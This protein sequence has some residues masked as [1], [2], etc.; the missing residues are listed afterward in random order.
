M[1]D[2]TYTT[3]D[4]QI[5][6]LKSQHLQF[7]DEENAKSRLQKYGYYNIINGYRD[8]FIIRQDST[9][10]Y[11]PGTTFEQIFALFALDHKLRNAVLLSTIDFEEQLKASV[12]E[13]I[14]CD[15]GTTVDEYLNKDNYRDKRVRDPRFSR[16][17][18]LLS[19][20]SLAHKA[21][22]EPIKYYKEQHGLIPP[23]ILMKGVFFGT[24]VN[25]IRLFKSPQRDKL[26]VSLYGKDR[27]NIPDEELKG[28][29]S[30]SLFLFLEYRNHA[31]H[32][33][34]IYNYIPKAK[35][36]YMDKLS[37]PQGLPQL[38]YAFSYLLHT[39]PYRLMKSVL[40]DALD[41]YGTAYPFDIDR[42]GRLTGFTIDKT[43]MVFL[44]ERT[45]K[46]HLQSSCSGLTNLYST[47][48]THAGLLGYTPCKRC[49]KEKMILSIMN[50]INNH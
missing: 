10:Y 19:M 13:I 46:Y 45:K 41:E 29:M 14:A 48:L 15:F 2:L 43:P 35:V 6:K 49:C 5:D 33:G 22:F 16:E 34:R 30:D 20:R 1:S 11:C 7:V 31:A 37:I 36:R 40:D 47:P 50:T 25:F 39:S 8:P 42:I 9:K 26:L 32:E 4:E 3:I 17:S 24:L 18:I 27:I 12:A 28:L 23:W 44:N 21:P 38:M